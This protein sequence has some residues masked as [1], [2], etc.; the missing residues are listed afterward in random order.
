MRTKV[1]NAKAGLV[2]VGFMLIVLFAGISHAGL[3]QHP[4]WIINIDKNVQQID[5]T[6][7]KVTK[8]DGWDVVDVLI[9]DGEIHR[10]FVN[11]TWEAKEGD[12]AS[13]AFVIGKIGEIRTVVPYLVLFMGKTRIELR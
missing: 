3:K 6:I 5:G 10:F 4:D 1:M 9:P 2:I 13:I 11:P 7:H 8:E 12:K